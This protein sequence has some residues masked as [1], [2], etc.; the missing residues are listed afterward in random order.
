VKSLRAIKDAVTSKAGLKLLRL[1]KHS[2]AILFAAGTVGVVGTVV[3]ACRATLR[4]DDILDEH[5]EM[6]GKMEV[7][8]DANLVEY[9]ENDYKQDK[10]KLYARTGFNIVKL[11]GPAIGV[12]VASIAALSGAHVILSRR[13][14]GLTAAYAALDR[15]YREYRNRVE[16]EVGPERERELYSGTRDREIVEETKEGAVVK[17]VKTSSGRSPYSFL[18]DKVNAES[19]SPDPGYNQMFLRSVQGYANDKLRAHG[20]ILLND[21]LDMLGMERTKAGCVVGWVLDGGNSDNYVDFGV[22]EG[23]TWKAIQ[24]VNGAE[25]SVWLD[26]NVDGV[27]Y[28]KLPG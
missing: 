12:G 8:R 7:A 18:F 27:I 21:V 6:A 14:V 24:F 22:F 5:H 16:K 20:Y 1:Q 19:W 11:Y 2:P 23:D 9:T 15:A 13:N 4:I 10:V 25:K 17:T 26:F 28:D 3:L